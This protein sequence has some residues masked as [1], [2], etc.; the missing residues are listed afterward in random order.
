MRKEEERREMWNQLRAGILALEEDGEWIE[1]E[2]M[3]R[4][5]NENNEKRNHEDIDNG[6]EERGDR[7][8]EVAED[9]GVADEHDDDVR[10]EVKDDEGGERRCDDQGDVEGGKHDGS[11]E[12][13]MNA[14]DGDEAKMM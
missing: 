3:L 1:E 10:G 6:A 8:Q 5:G 2:D 9:N 14:R 13:M 12:V 7:D 4:R 11:P